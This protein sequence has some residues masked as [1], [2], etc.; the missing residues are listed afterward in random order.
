MSTLAAYLAAQQQAKFGALFSNSAFLANARSQDAQWHIWTDGEGVVSAVYNRGRW[1]DGPE[2]KVEETYKGERMLEIAE[3]YLRQ[4]KALHGLG[5]IFHAGD[6][7]ATA[8]VKESMAGPENWSSAR[9]TLIDDPAAVLDEKA[10][11]DNSYRYVPTPGSGSACAVRMGLREKVFASMVSAESRVQLSVESA[12]LELIQTARDF[13]LQHGDSAKSGSVILLV[14]P[15]FT[16]LATVRESTGELCSLINL[17]HTAKGIPANVADRVLS[18]M[19]GNM[20]E[21]VNVWLVQGGVSVERVLKSI[22][23]DFQ[24]HAQNDLSFGENVE[25]HAIGCWKGDAFAFTGGG[26]SPTI[27]DA[28]ASSHKERPHRDIFRPEFLSG[29][30]ANGFISAA[31]ANQNFCS[32]AILAASSRITRTEAV[33]YNV[34]KFGR[35]AACLAILAGAAFGGLSAYGRIKSPAWMLEPK[36][37]QD[38]AAKV[39]RLSQLNRSII[40]WGNLFRPRSEAWVSMEFLSRLFPESDKGFLL[41]SVRYDIAPYAPE[42]KPGVALEKATSLGYVKQWV[43]KGF[44]TEGQREQLGSKRVEAALADTEAATGR[45][46]FCEGPTQRLQVSF[47]SDRQSPIVVGGVAYT[48][49]FTLT[50]DLTVLPGDTEALPVGRAPFPAADQTAP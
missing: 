13:L 48:S 26:E 30:K 27:Y 29:P 36:L 50:L 49:N 38:A 16:A 20:L 32:L 40:F 9:L 47:S 23:A 4:N 44:A 11:T 25:L 43:I 15:R 28:I 22:I 19:R 41:N 17:P 12:P 8:T 46:L 10:Q 34:V 18:E 31:I 42:K 39:D 45:R 35:V 3:S 21:R 37:A 7:F 2:L 24:S 14:F 1:A 5:V 33:I 6:D